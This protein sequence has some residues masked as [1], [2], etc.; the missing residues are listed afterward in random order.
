MP[1]GSPVSLAFVQR[2][3]SRLNRLP[4]R[5]LKREVKV[6][7]NLHSPVIQP[8]LAIF[9][10][11]ILTNVFRIVGGFDKK[12][13]NG[14]Y[15]MDRL[16]KG[17]LH[18]LAGDIVVFIKPVQDIGLPLLGQLGMADRRIEGRSPGQPRDHR[19]LAKG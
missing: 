3:Q 6:G 17:F 14:P 5:L 1:H 9:C 2:A 10:N 8:F 4:C 18:L 11:N 19:A 12:G 13:I 7:R 15:G 16:R